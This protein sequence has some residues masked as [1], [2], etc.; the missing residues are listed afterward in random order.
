MKSIKIFNKKF[1]V[2]VVLFS[3]DR[4]QVKYTNYRFIPIWYPL[5]FWFEQTLTGGNE[6]WTTDLFKV[7]EA[8]RIAKKLKTIE[9]VAEW[10]KPDEEKRI[11]FYKRQTEHYKKAVPYNSKEF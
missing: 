10:Y 8:E 1:K 2:K 4:Y 11:I 5:C 3:G 9:D 6:C 7:E